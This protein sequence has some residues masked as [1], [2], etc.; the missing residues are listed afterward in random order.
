MRNKFVKENNKTH[1]LGKYMDSHVA[2]QM[3]EQRV[4]WKVVLGKNKFERSYSDLKKDWKCE[5]C[6]MDCSTTQYLSYQMRTHNQSKKSAK[7]EINY[8]KWSLWSFV[9][10]ILLWKHRII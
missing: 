2:K 1:F 10:P 4:L 8:E 5:I 3:E 9:N 6:R 7:S